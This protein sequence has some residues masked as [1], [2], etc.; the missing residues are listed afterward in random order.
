MK[1]KILQCLSLILIVSFMFTSAACRGKVSDSSGLESETSMDSNDSSDSS[2]TES[3]LTSQDST[4]SNNTS[5]KVTTNGSN[6]QTG[7]GK[8]WAQ[9][10]SKMPKSLNGTTIEFL[11]YHDYNEF[12]GSKNV[13]TKF[14]KETGIK[15]KWVT[16]DYNSY[17]SELAARVNAGRSPDMFQIFTLSPEMMQL[18]QPLSV[19][20]FD[21]SDAAWDS[22]V[23]N[24]YTYHGKQYAANLANTLFQSPTAMFYN[25][26]IIQQYGYE[27][28]YDLW[29]SGKWTYDKWLEICRQYKKDSGKTPFV[30]N[31]AHSIMEMYG[32]GFIE[33]ENGKAVSKMDDSR[34]VKAWE[35]VAALKKEGIMQQGDWQEAEWS[36]GNALFAT[37]MYSFAR[38]TQL[39]SP[40]LKSA[41]YLAVVPLP[42]TDSNSKNVAA[43]T[44]MV[45]YC[46]AKGAKNPQAVPYFIRFFM[47]ANNYSA[48]TVFNDAQNLEVYQSLMARPTRVMNCGI[49]GISTTTA[50]IAY[51]PEFTRVLESLSV[52]QVKGKLDSFK[53]NVNK[54]VE[55]INKSISKM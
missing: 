32:L 1:K 13:V 16:V 6:T 55:S 26:S 19:S 29:K 28:P 48:K 8:S 54:A 9:V 20:G 3:E 4:T 18:M 51:Y 24:Y 41:G 2:G 14:T 36:N 7:A 37:W 44:E 43:W 49:G 15:I 11:T 10:L 35:Q 21:F 40:S 46:I 22:R 12:P 42:D 34:M 53:P 33:Y 39:L 50:G 52:D 45:A 47:D 31:F 25:R 38:T 17:G 5:S 27:D 30:Q 23:L